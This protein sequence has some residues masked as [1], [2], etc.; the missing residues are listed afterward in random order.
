MP[1]IRSSRR[2][3]YDAAGADELCFLDISASHEG[4]GTLLDMVGAPPK[5]ASCR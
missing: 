3:A 2:R 5:C 4:R 1:A